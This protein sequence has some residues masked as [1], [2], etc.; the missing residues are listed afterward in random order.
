MAIIG[1]NKIV[2]Y[3][4]KFKHGWHRAMAKLEQYNI[5][6]FIQLKQN[7]FLIVN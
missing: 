6:E 2:L 5:T 3:L 4:M 1:E 7:S